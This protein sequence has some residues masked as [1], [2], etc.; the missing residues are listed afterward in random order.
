MMPDTAQFR[1]YLQMLQVFQTVLVEYESQQATIQSQEAEIHKLNLSSADLANQVQLLE[2]EKLQLEKR[3]KKFGE[4]CKNYKDHMND[5]VKSQRQLMQQSITLRQRAAENK[6]E[7][8]DI[9]KV[10][11]RATKDGE[12]YQCK[13]KESS[14]IA[15]EL[16][17]KNSGLMKQA[18]DCGLLLLCSLR[19]ANSTYYSG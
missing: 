7:A 18:E 19:Q 17:V 8:N 11:K 2:G 1:E 6:E 12:T 10:L 4:L 16:G 5:V 15:R 14:K 9:S 13:L 3:N